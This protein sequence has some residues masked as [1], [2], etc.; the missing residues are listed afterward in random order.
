[1][2]KKRKIA[3]SIIIISC[4]ILIVLLFHESILQAVGDF[5]IIRDDLQPA[6]VI[7]VIAGEDHRTQY[8]IQLYQDGYGEYLFFTGGW[9]DTHQYFHGQYALETALAAGISKDA[10]FVDDSAI[11][12]TYSEAELLRSF[13]STYQEP[14][15]TVIVVSDPHHMRRA[16]WTYRWVLGEQI[17][18]QMAPVP[19]DL[20]PRQQRW[21]TDE[22]SSE[23]V[24]SEYGKIV[25]YRLRYQ[26]ATGRIKDYLAS[27]DTE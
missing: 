1:M 7:H 15:N 5:L 20:S 9:C 11:T 22:D 2:G 25:Y 6:D 26:F 19:F 3:V 21:W 14:V 12:S 24:I 8:A 17:D 13:I 4:T 27:L 23:M 18:V 16:R 10:V